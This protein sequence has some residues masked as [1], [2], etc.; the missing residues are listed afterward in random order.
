MAWLQVYYKEADGAFVVFDCTRAHTLDGARTW[1]KD[2]DS[3]VSLADDQ[4]LPTILLANKVCPSS[5]P[6]CNITSLLFPLM[7]DVRGIPSMC[8]VRGLPP[9]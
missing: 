8:D 7:C 9:M 1:K 2:L 4:H 6:F 3:K 5:P